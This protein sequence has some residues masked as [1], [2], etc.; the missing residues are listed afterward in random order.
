MK[1]L[2]Q[3]VGA[4]RFPFAALLFILRHPSVWPWCILPILINAVMVLLVWHWTGHYADHWMKGHLQGDQWWWQSARWIVAAFILIARLLLA[5]AAF[6]VVGNVAA[7][8]FNDL[9][10]ERVDILLGWGDE[11]RLTLRRR[12]VELACTAL[13]ELKRVALF[14]GISSG[15][16]VMSLT[17]VLTIVTAPLQILV[18]AEFFALD[19]LSFP[20]ERRGMLL[21]ERKIGFTR[22]HALRCLGFGTAMTVIGIV[23]LVN[24]FFI[25]LGVV[26][27]TLLHAEIQRTAA[28]REH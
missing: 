20:L 13:Q 14:I 6:V 12:I 18:S 28:P 5:L 11:R 19:Y 17:G 23:P 24:F 1:K 4:M 26:G 27:G 21:L 2:T 3:Y 22:D 9:L 15:L 25:P 10:S 8:P 16:L 7:V